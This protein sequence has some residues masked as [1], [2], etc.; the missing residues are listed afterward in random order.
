[1]LPDARTGFYRSSRFDWS[2]MISSARYQ[3]REYL[4]FPFSEHRPEET[5]YGIGTAEEFRACVPG[6]ADALG[7]PEAGVGDGFIK[8]GVGILRKDAREAYHFAKKYELMKAG[9]WHLEFADRSVFFS[10]TLILNARHGYEYVKTIALDAEK[11]V[12]T[13]THS[14]KNLGAERIHIHHYCHNFFL[15]DAGGVGSNDRALFPFLPQM[16]LGRCHGS[17]YLR[18]QENTVGFLRNIANA[19]MVGGDVVGYASTPAHNTF[20]MENG[21]TGIGVRVSSDRPAVSMYL[22]AGERFFSVEPQIEIKC[23]TGERM[24]WT[25]TYELYAG[26]PAISPFAI[27]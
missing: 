25:N 27:A 1:M 22:C 7:Y 9:E 19:D 4:G 5:Q 3:G 8:I 17:E 6:V 11:P 2:G 26:V 21:R 18:V 24:E 12:F 14:L 16:E 15:M 20:R 23:Q 13:I 10:Q